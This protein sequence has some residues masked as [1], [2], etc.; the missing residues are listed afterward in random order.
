MVIN[1]TGVI[2]IISVSQV[3]IV[4]VAVFVTN[5]HWPVTALVQLQL[6]RFVTLFQG[7]SRILA[8]QHCLYLYNLPATPE[9]FQTISRVLVCNRVLVRVGRK[10]RQKM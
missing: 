4:I 10:R 2:S 7:L 5:H 8:P 9:H 3:Y 1:N 6:Q